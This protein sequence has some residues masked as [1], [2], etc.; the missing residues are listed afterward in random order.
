MK[1]ILIAFTLVATLSACAPRWEPSQTPFLTPEMQKSVDAASQAQGAAIQKILRE[2]E[3]DRER[4]EEAPDAA[5]L[6]AQERERDA[7]QALAGLCEIE[8]AS[9]ESAIRQCVND[10]ETLPSAQLSI[11]LKVHVAAV[12][13]KMAHADL[14][15]YVKTCGRNCSSLTMSDLINAAAKADMEWDEIG[16]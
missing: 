8:F 13:R 6:A 7:R 11:A 16:Q 2:Q 10:A 3:E 12:D 5:V 1:R 15:R 4:K 14:D 9:A